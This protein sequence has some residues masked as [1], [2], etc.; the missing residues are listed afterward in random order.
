MV[1]CPTCD[2]II[3]DTSDGKRKLRARVLLFEDDG[4]IA[5]CPQCK[6][7]VRVP[8]TLDGAQTA[9]SP[10]RHVILTD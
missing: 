9:P 1:H 3:L 2:R 10:L 7:G 4:T 8:V 5:V 6:M